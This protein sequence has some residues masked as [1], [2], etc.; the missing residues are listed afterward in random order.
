M[1]KLL[2]LIIV[3][4]MLLSC[5]KDNINDPLFH[6]FKGKFVFDDLIE[7]SYEIFTL[8]NVDSRQITNSVPD[9]VSP[10]W[11]ADGKKV[12]YLSND[13]GVLNIHIM[14]E[15]GLNDKSLFDIG[16][17]NISSLFYPE[18]KLSPNGNF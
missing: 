10:Q 14:D 8:D 18:L 6:G 12:M 17:S 13:S 4:S 7:S 5:E 15:Q 11:L 9:K 3:F 1:Y 16:T 2:G